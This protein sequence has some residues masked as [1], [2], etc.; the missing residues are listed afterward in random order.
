MNCA[1]CGE[2]FVSPKKAGC[3]VRHCSDKC[4]HESR[5]IASRKYTKKNRV[6]EYKE[7]R[8][9]TIC[10][11][12]FIAEGKGYHRRY[13]SH[14]CANREEHNKR[15]K[16]R[17]DNTPTSTCPQCGKAFKKHRK[18]GTYCSQECY[19]E[20][21]KAKEQ[22]SVCRI[23]GKEFSQKGNKL[24]YCSSICSIR[25][26]AEVYK[27]NTLTRRAL[28]VINGTVEK[29]NPK[30]IF[31]RDG[32]RCQICGKATPMSRRGTCYPNAPE[33]DHRVPISKGGGHLYS[34]VQCSCRSCNGK[35]SNHSEAGQ[36]SLL[37]IETTTYR[38][39]IRSLGI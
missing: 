4:R 14:K 7:S 39:R 21:L 38:G 3:P 16:L 33:L 34:N 32:Y 13:C 18:K 15:N 5:L 36:L 10:G 24:K 1:F 31:E 11:A 2:D 35:K 23:C 12:S 26:Q 27:R 19:L 28:R 25:A 37:T 22:M 6:K 17:L 30:D 29:I 8:V 9:C 20:S